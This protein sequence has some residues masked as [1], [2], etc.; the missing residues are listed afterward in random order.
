VRVGL[1]VSDGDGVMELLKRG[2]SIIAFDNVLSR[3]GRYV[4]REYC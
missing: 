3:I 4:R 1:D 2:H